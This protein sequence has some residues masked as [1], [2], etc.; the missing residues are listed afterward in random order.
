MKRRLTDEEM[1][2]IDEELSRR[3]PGKATWAYRLSLITI[4]IANV[5]LF[6]F[7]IKMVVKF[8]IPIIKNFVG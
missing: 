8:T 2:R 3:P 1:G 6:Y 4:L 5:V 7:I